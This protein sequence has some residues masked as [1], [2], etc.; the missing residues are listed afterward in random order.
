VGFRERKKRV[1][2]SLRTKDREQ[3]EYL[4]KNENERLWDEYYSGIRPQKPQDRRFR[5]IASEYIDYVKDIRKASAWKITRSRLRIIY[6]L[7][8]DIRLE[9]VDHQKLVDLDTYLKNT[10][11]P[12]SPK[13]I[14]HY[15]KTLSAMFNFAIRKGYMKYNFAKEVKPY[16]VARK[17]REYSREEI[18]RILE[19][20]DRIELEAWPHATLQPYAKRIILILLYTGMRSGELVNLKWSDVKG[21]RITLSETETKQKKETIIPLSDGLRAILDSIP[22]KDEYVIPRRRPGETP[23]P[24]TLIR[25]IKKLTGIED[26]DL[27]KFRHT[28]ASWLIASGVDVVTVKELLGHSSIKTTE[29]YSHSSY[30]R[31]KKAVEILEGTY[32]IKGEKDAIQD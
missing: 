29:I 10:K 12:R 21:D 19:A 8:G 2:F 28:A 11:P 18:A 5:V 3:A 31:K 1:R 6:E 24:K 13:T 16:T 27:H 9:Q 14:N 20:A 22:K 25:K 23:C 26:F 15:M 7:W 17:R 32:I 30:D 4:W